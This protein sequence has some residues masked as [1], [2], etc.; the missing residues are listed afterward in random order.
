MAGNISLTKIVFTGLVG[1]FLIATLF[2]VYSEFII[3][4]G[5]TIDE[6]YVSAFE[7]IAAQYG[8]FD[9]TAKVASDQGFVKNILDFGRNAI[10]GTVNVF[11]VGLTSI[12]SLFSLLPIIGNVFSALGT[13]VPAL[14]GVLGLLTII[15]GLY[16]PM[17]YIVSVTNKPDLP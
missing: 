4:N 6:K 11:V 10:T 14:N 15:I 5:A 2:G 3:L 17:R 7:K 9:S 8:E 1:T 16:I 12:G 13:A